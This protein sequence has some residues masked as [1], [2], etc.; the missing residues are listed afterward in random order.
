VLGHHTQRTQRWFGTAKDRIA[1]STLSWGAAVCPSK[2]EPSPEASG[3]SRW[4][5]PSYFDVVKEMNAHVG[6]LA[7]LFGL[8]V[9]GTTFT[10]ANGP[11]HETLNAPSPAI[12]FQLFLLAFDLVFGGVSVLAAMDPAVPIYLADEAAWTRLIIQKRH[13]CTWILGAILATLCVLISLWGEPFYRGVELSVNVV[14]GANGLWSGVLI[15]FVLVE[16]AQSGWG[17]WL[18]WQQLWK[19]ITARSRSSSQPP[20]VPPPGSS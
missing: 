18:L 15:S 6:R 7:T 5:P 3:S 19:R 16:V 17:P 14:A 1:K 13:L 20:S 12:T 11:I 10:L 4:E 8:L 2:V 9:A